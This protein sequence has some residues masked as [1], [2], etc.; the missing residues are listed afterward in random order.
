L[1]CFLGGAGVNDHGA[2]GMDTGGLVDVKDGD[3][4]SDND[5]ESG[6]NPKE[7]TPTEVTPLKS[8]V[9]GKLQ[10]KFTE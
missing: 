7:S 3:D 2:L 5:S 1:F 8:H 4:D 10:C 6:L 9:V